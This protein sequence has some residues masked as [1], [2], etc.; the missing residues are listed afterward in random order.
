MG[1]QI[2]QVMTTMVTMVRISFGVGSGEIW[3]L[4]TNC[5]DALRYIRHCRF[6]GHICEASVSSVTC[7][8]TYHCY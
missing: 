8:R 5:R 3:T 4:S 7:A 6:R 2:L 1:Y